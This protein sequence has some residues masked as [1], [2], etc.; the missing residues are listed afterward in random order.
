MSQ[1]FR[2]RCLLN[3]CWLIECERKKRSAGKRSAR[4]LLKW[5]QLSLLIMI[6][7]WSGS[8][9]WG[10]DI[11]GPAWKGAGSHCDWEQELWS[12]ATHVQVLGQPFPAE[13]PWAGRFPGRPVTFWVSVSSLGKWGWEPLKPAISFVIHASW[14]L[15]ITYI[16]FVSAGASSTLIWSRWRVP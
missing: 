2:V 12:K 14:Y 16:L 7:P 4:V 8:R 5:T 10:Q 15:V 6:S 1:C 9:C 3:T 11:S 13:W